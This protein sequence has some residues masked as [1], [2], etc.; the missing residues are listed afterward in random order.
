MK[1]RADARPSPDGELAGISPG[2]RLFVVRLEDSLHGSRS[3]DPFDKLDTVTLGLEI[4]R[5][6]EIG[7]VD[8]EWR[9]GVRGGQPHAALGAGELQAG[10]DP[11]E[12]GAE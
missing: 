9:H 6:A 5:V 4:G 1:G 12:P 11:E 3:D 10:R 8:V 7:M 2:R